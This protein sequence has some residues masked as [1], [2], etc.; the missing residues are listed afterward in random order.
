MQRSSK[1]PGY[2]NASV[3]FVALDAVVQGNHTWF[4]G[5]SGTEIGSACFSCRRCE[6]LGFGK[7]CLTNLMLVHPRETKTQLGFT[8]ARVSL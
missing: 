7:A 4:I 3:T 2:R 8:I 1:I 6:Q 5:A